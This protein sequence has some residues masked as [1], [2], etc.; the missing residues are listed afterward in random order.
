[1][2]TGSLSS[3]DVHLILADGASLTVHDDINVAEG[4]SFTVYAQSTG[5]AMGV[6][7]AK[8]KTENEAGIGGGIW[9]NAGTITINSGKVTATGGMSLQPESAAEIKAS[10]GMITINGGNI[11]ANGGSSEAGSAADF[12]VVRLLAARLPSTT[13]RSLQMAAIYTAGI[14]DGN[15]AFSRGDITING[16]IVTA[17]G[18]YG[19]GS[20]ADMFVLLAPSSSSA[21]LSPQ[22]A[23]MRRPEWRRIRYRRQCHHQW[24]Q[25]HCNRR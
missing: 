16:G 12:R 11:T 24:R 13:A 3:G 25:C 1:M 7:T 10:G 4:N 2:T 21:A 14:G 20:A 17:T 9:E 6:L 8:D 15:Q 22:P 19:A 5:A 23:E 18:G